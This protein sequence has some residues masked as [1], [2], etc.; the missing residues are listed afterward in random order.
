MKFLLQVSTIGGIFISTLGIVH[1]TAK[2]Q[3][4]TFIN[5][6]N[7]RIGVWNI[8]EKVAPR[9]PSVPTS[10]ELFSLDLSD[11]TIV[12]EDVTEIMGMIESRNLLQH[13]QKLDLSNN[14]LTLEGVK[15]LIPLLKNKNFQWLDIST[16]NLVVSDLHQ[17]WEEIEKYANRVSIIEEIGTTEGLRDLWASKV[18]LLPRN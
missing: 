10:T 18:V 4:P 5:L 12:D 17:L 8:E 14:R 15:A 13:L 1:G 2:V 11:N 7:Q 16:N 9:L 3:E 6:H